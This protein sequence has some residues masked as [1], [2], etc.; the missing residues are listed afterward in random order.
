MTFSFRR[1][2]KDEVVKGKVFRGTLKDMLT[3]KYASDGNGGFKDV[4]T[5][6]EVYV[7]IPTD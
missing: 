1:R 5:F 2:I 7:K 6:D 4:V 3:L